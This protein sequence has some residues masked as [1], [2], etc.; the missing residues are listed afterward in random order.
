PCILLN[1]LRLFRLANAIAICV[2]TWMRW[3]VEQKVLANTR[4]EVDLLGAMQLGVYGE[5]GHLNVVHKN[6]QARYATQLRW[7]RQRAS[8]PKSTSSNAH[9]EVVMQRARTTNSLCFKVVYRAILVSVQVQTLRRNLFEMN[10]HSSNLS[11][12]ISEISSSVPWQ[13]K[14][15]QN[16][17]HHR[18]GARFP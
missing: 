17:K 15:E 6:L 1:G 10:F 8:C 18:R 14:P 9:V 5:C 7:L 13:H 4:R 16:R 2:A 11:N 3:Q 12:V